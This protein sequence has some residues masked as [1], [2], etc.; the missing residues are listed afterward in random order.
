[1]TIRRIS[2]VLIFV[3]GTLINGSGFAQQRV[4]DHLH[5]PL[6]EKEALAIFQYEKFIEDVSA[7]AR[8]EGYDYRNDHCFRNFLY[9][10]HAGTL[11]DV[12]LAY[13]EES[14]ASAYKAIYTRSIEKYREQLV[15]FKRNEQVLRAEFARRINSAIP[16][17]TAGRPGGPTNPAPQAACANMDFES[18]TLNGWT[19]NTNISGGTG[20]SFVTTPGNDAN[21]PAIPMVY[22][23]GFSACL[24]AL[25]TSSG[26]LDFVELSQTFMVTN[27][28][29][30]FLFYTAVIV[31]AGA[32]ACADNPKFEVSV[33]NSGNA[34]IPCSNISLIGS[35]SGGGNCSQ[36][37]GW[38]TVGGY[39]YL[40][41]SPVIVP[42]QAYLGQN[43]T[44]KFRVQRC[45]GGGGHGAKAYVEA[46]CNPQALT[47]TGSIVCAGNP[48]GLF[49]PN[50]PGYSYSWTSSNGF[51]ASTRTI[52][53]TQAGT[54]SVTITNTSNAGCQMKLDTVIL[55]VPN[56]TA[57]F[58]VN[59]TPC[60]PTFSVPVVSTSIPGAPGDP[61]AGYSWEWGDATANGSGANASHTYGSAGTKTIELVVTSQGG[62]KD[63][64]RQPVTIVPG[65]TAAFATANVCAGAL[66]S[67]NST[68]TP[69]APATMASQVWIFGDGSANGMGA[70]TVHS[71]TS[72]GTYNVK[73]VVTNNQLC[74]D[75]IVHPITIFPKPAVSFSASPVCLGTATSFNNTS[76]V[77]APNT[78]SSWA[79]DFDNN[80]TTDN[81]TQSPSNNF[82]PAGS[83]V[84]KLKA[85]SNNG[86]A[87]SATA[88][89]QVNPMPVVNFTAANACMNS[90]VGIANTSSVSAGS[91]ATWGWNFGA[92]A[93]PGLSSVQAPGSLSYNTP[94]VKTI[95]LTATTN[96]SC[97]AV[98]TNTV[99]I[100][101]Q[102][103]AAFAASSVCAGL[104]TTF[105]DQS[106]PALPAAD[107]VS[108][109]TWDLNN[110]GV[111]D[112][113]ASAPSYTYGASGTYTAMMI[114]TTNNGCKDTVYVPVSV[115]GHATVDFS[116]TN[117][118][119]GTA[120][121]FTNQTSFSTQPNT[122]TGSG[123]SW[124][125]G[126][127]G[128]SG[129][130]SPIYTYT[131]GAN[132]NT[133]YTVKLVV[134][135]SH[136]CVDSTSKTVTVYSLP[137]PS[138]TSDS[139]CYN[140]LS[141]LVDASNGN[142]NTLTG[143][144]WDF[145]GDNVA[146]VSGV[147]NPNY[148]FPAFGNTAVNYT[149]STTP[150]AG[151]S[152][153]SFTTQNV[154]VHPLPVPAF[155]F[156][157]A[158]VN[159]QP[160]LFDASSSTIPV[161]TNTLYAW[162]YGDAG[163]GNGQQ[164]SHTYAAAGAYSTTLTVTSNKGCVK[165]LVQQVA[166]YE[167]PKMTFSAAHNCFGSPTTFTASALPGSG[168]PGQWF[169]DFNN[170]ITSI[171][172]NGQQ[173][174]YTFPSAGSQ[175]ISLV[176]ISTAPGYCRDTV[177][178]K[179]Y[180]NYMPH[181]QFT[182]DKPAGCPLPH[183]VTFTDN[184]PAVQGPAQIVNWIWRFGDGSTTN[185]GTNASQSHCYNNTS[186]STSA[187]F[188]VTLIA[189]TDSAC[190]DSMV[191]NSYIT[192][193]PKPIADYTVSS[194]T[195]TEPL[196][197]FSNQSIDYTKWWWYFGDGPA[198][199]SV[200]VDPTHYY[201][202]DNADTY[203]TRLIVA[204]QYGCRDTA[205]APV[206][207]GPEFV[208]YIP[209][210][211]TPGNGDNINDGFIGRGIGIVKHEMWIFDRWGVMIYYTNDINKPW[212]GTV[213]GKSNPVQQDVY[214]WKVKL[215]DVL[216]KKHDYVG[217][218]TVLRGN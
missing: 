35:A 37:T 1:M 32:H 159:A 137:T 3:V 4:A 51:T 209:N 125:F 182:V 112:G 90:N 87:D 5:K 117:V 81:T 54:Y 196:V 6:N 177:T 23:G 143:Y 122:G 43:V 21:V 105:T 153:S 33:L 218:V 170:S 61:I 85:T 67:F 199:D 20:P 201:N 184:T 165:K 96:A 151:L 126:N 168:T 163:S 212:D 208:F 115:W 207:I 103:V 97:T 69:P 66:A 94:G 140:A 7:M 41:W 160:I 107:A 10:A 52:S 148:T 13:S 156:T 104:A 180:V 200:N 136:N 106:T 205:Y 167:K 146:D 60:S 215:L 83:Y 128:T 12:F 169:W 102:P 82:T 119:F 58:N 166:V 134:T 47:G 174:T 59:F 56:P 162:Q 24:D 99:S 11:N 48:V 155:S 111:M 138:F 95:T 113:T 39:D 144:A 63:S 110:D 217:H 65:P 202:S 53:V 46:S 44:I 210:A 124:T 120:T 197:Y 55:A 73:L 139:A 194:G 14:P 80:G 187:L 9:F 157:N 86:C 31:D 45:N 49:A 179:I 190:V 92:G 211:F 154:W 198:L 18:G 181:P 164:V 93:T 192:V 64:I 129:S 173:A 178:R 118:C 189:V 141:H 183:C 100:Y 142:G 88:M 15:L 195:V 72:P 91:I 62:C 36:Y 25:T 185:A 70:S 78:I 30:D 28:N 193:Y 214:V 40:N 50:L 71:Y 22:A 127:G 57:S 27:A 188:D 8:Q 150:A 74:K 84:V 76:T 186:S 77:A 34:V 203:P 109:W 19:T 135:T 133:T 68:S 79:W 213:Q 89:I 147:S 108:A 204:N 26:N 206:T 130:Q 176:T 149:V 172:G 75:S 145:T 101:A 131:N 121:S 38:Q 158:C 29:K 17:T 152:C 42:L 161:G 116:P 114:A 171:E 132:A 216:G 175:T 2:I 191:K 16:G 123:W 98:F